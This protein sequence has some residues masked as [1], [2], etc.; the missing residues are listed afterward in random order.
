MLS[1]LSYWTQSCFHMTVIVFM[2]MAALRLTTANLSAAFLNQLLS[3]NQRRKSNVLQLHMQIFFLFFAHVNVRV[4]HVFPL[5]TWSWNAVLSPPQCPSSGEIL[6][7]FGMSNLSR[8]TVGDLETI[9]PAVLTQVLLP[10]CPHTV[11]EESYPFR[12]SGQLLHPFVCA[13][14][15]KSNTWQVTAVCCS[16]RCGLARMW[17]GWSF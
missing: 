16:R 1:V 7:H 11:Q 17:V 9:C 4:C 8:L 6:S 14:P 15:R 13:A 5:Y 3:N 2:L 10:S 12:Y